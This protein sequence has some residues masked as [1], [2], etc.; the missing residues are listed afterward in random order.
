M[1]LET[2]LMTLTLTRKM[3]E[4]LKGWQTMKPIHFPI[5]KETQTARMIATMTETGSEKR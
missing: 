2:G 1:H 4:S 3:T 5:M